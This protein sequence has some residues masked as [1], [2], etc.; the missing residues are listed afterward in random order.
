VRRVLGIDLAM[1]QAYWLSRFSDAARQ[2]E[3]YRAGRVLVAGDAAHIQ[4]PAGGP[5]MTTG[6]QDAVNLGWKLAA[7]IRGWAPPGLLDTYHAERHPVAARMLSFVRAQSVLLAPGEQ[8]SALRDLVGELLT[9]QQPLRYVV[10]RLLGLDIRYD[11]GTTPAHPLVGGWAPDLPLLTDHG[12]HG[13]PSS[14]APAGRC[15]LTSPPTAGCKGNPYLKGV[16]GEVAAAAAKTDTF[17]GERYRRLVRRIGKR[18][19]LVA[20]ARSI[21][22]I[23]WHLLADPTARF[24][25]LGADYHSRRI[26]KDRKT[27]SHVRQLQALG[28]TVTLTPAA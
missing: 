23:V 15:C 19:A 13:W 25:D 3:V 28:Y 24:H 6:L 1:G 9:H 21:L 16:L 22:V 18:K 2:A 27:R 10:D 8:V 26:D 7:T 12:P 11:P 4:L 20:I 5:G 17:L 14:C